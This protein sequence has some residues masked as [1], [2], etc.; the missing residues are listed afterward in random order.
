MLLEFMI[1]AL[2]GAILAWKFQVYILLPASLIVIPVAIAI[3]VSTGVGIWW[4][5]L[6]TFLAVASL[7]FG[8]L[9]GAATNFVA[10]GTPSESYERQ[11]T[12]GLYHLARAL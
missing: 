9:I 11:T 6:E 7:Q 8:Y 12:L 4:T 10:V 3:G 5:A 1:A 2:I